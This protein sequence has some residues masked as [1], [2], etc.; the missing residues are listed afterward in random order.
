[1]AKLAII[2]A[3]QHLRINQFAQDSARKIQNRA[4]AVVVLS[5]GAAPFLGRLIY[6]SMCKMCLCKSGWTMT[7]RSYGC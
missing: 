1:M 3:L 2:Q 7:A 4:K 6:H 5:D